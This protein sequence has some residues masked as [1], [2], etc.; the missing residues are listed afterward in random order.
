MDRDYDSKM[1]YSNFDDMKKYNPNFNEEQMKDKTDK[2]IRTMFKEYYSEHLPV[3]LLTWMRVYEPKNEMCYKKGYWNQAVFVR[4]EINKM[5]YSKY[6]D[7]KANPV[8]VI[9][10]HRS[11][12]II[13]PVYY[14]F[15]EEYNTKIIMR[16]NFYDWKIS[17]DSKYSIT[18]IDEFFKEKEP[19]NP[20]YCEGFEESQVY[21]MYKE[22]NKH[23]TIELSSNYYEVYIFFYMLKKSLKERNR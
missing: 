1:D 4:D 6:E 13:L 16:N 14:I 15:L 8:K 11:K 5:F 12:S 3:D 19:V 9:S 7:Y 18:G 17:I 23:F 20:I 10:T 2:E 21:G 22:N